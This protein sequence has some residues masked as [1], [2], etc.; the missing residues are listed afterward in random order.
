LD[1]EEMEPTTDGSLARGYVQK[2][3]NGNCIHHDLENSL[4]RIWERR[5]RVCR[6]YECNSDPLLQF[7]VKHGFTSLKQLITNAANSYV[8]KEHFIS[9]PLKNGDSDGGDAD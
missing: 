7:V 9:I 8:P 1:P 5:P 4:C 3:K 2:D 6:E